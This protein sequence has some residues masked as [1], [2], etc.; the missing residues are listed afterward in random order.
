MSFNNFHVIPHEL[1]RELYQ[2]TEPFNY[3]TD[4]SRFVSSSECSQFVPGVG[5]K[6][7]SNAVTSGL[8]TDTESLLHNRYDALNSCPYTNG[9]NKNTTSSNFCCNDCKHGLPCQ[10]NKDGK[11]CKK[12]LNCK[13]FSIPKACERELVPVNTR[14][15]Y[16]KPCNLPGAFF[17]RFEPQIDDFQN[18]ARIRSNDFIG[19][20][21]R[22][23]MRDK[24]KYMTCSKNHN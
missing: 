7:T 1:N 23:Y 24:Y 6:R 19:V 13:N 9:K 10:C 17:N 21:S 20:G 2:Q 11:K 12:C 16:Q 22:N 18:T 5:S 8:K 4:I 14:L 15:D 3:A